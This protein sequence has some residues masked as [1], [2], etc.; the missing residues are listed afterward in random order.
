MHM[1]WCRSCT[2]QQWQSTARELHAART[3]AA[4]L[5]VHQCHGVVL[6][7]RALHHMK[8]LHTRRPTPTPPTPH[9]NANANANARRR[10]T[11]RSSDIFCMKAGLDMADLHGQRVDQAAETLV[12]AQRRG[13]EREAGRVRQCVGS[14]PG[15]ARPPPPPPHTHPTHIICDICPCIA[16][17]AIASSICFICEATCRPAAVVESMRIVPGSHRKCG[18]SR[19]RSGHRAACKATPLL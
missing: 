19:S 14:S 1:G 3:H 10:A 9:A 12:D 18:W 2:R 13:R 7:I 17:L 11:H 8:H 16:G 5:A 6:Y 15:T 4:A